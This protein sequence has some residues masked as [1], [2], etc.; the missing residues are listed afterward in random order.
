MESPEPLGLVRESYSKT[1]VEAWISR[2]VELYYITTC[3][4][5]PIESIDDLL[6][7]N[8]RCERTSNEQIYG[9]S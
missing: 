8:E 3:P 5:P 6:L 1:E 2:H 7:T 4:R 9:P